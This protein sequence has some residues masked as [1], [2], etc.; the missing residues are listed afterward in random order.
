M[1]GKLL[2]AS[3]YYKLTVT[4]SNISWREIYPL[5]SRS[6]ILKAHFSFCSNFPREVTL[7]AQRNSRKSMVPS[8]LASNVLK[9]CSANWIQKNRKIKIRQL[10]YSKMKR[11]K[12]NVDSSRIK[13]GKERVFF[14]FRFIF[15]FLFT[16]YS[17][18]KLLFLFFLRHTHANSSL[19][20][21]IF[22]YSEISM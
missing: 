18:K 5:P 20:N 7:R 1:R 14:H 17:K 16:T 9:T 21:K 2:K 13:P 12:H 10:Q 11:K 6:Y 3:I 15:P 19:Y 4:I 8:P 22:L